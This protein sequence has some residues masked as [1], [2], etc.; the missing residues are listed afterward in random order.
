V[1]KY[2]LVLSKRASKFLDG[3]DRKTRL[4]VIADLDGLANFPFCDRSFDVIK[5]NGERDYYRLRTGSIR[6]VFSI[7]KSAEAVLVRKIA[8]RKAAYK[9]HTAAG[10]VIVH[11]DEKGKITAIEITDITAL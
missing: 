5:L 8:Y 2:R 10:K 4:R 3:L 11:Y 1:P 7:D 9:L 6:T